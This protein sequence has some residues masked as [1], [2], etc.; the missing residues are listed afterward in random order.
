LINIIRFYYLYFPRGSGGNVYL[1]QD[2]DSIQLFI[3]NGFIFASG[4]AFPNPKETKEQIEMIKKEFEGNK[5][6]L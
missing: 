4:S 2:E 6:K 3:L 1:A 5:Q